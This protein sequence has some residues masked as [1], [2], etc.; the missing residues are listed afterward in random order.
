M[1]K[2]IFGKLN[3]LRN[4]KYKMLGLLNKKK[5]KFSKKNI[6]TLGSL[7]ITLADFE[8]LIGQLRSKNI[9][10]DKKG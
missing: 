1:T 5:Y 8:D 6:E 3:I 4:I 7:V 10:L 2:S 9:K